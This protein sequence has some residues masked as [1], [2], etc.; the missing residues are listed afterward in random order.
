MEDESS[1]M[2][3]GSTQ[4]PTNTDP[5][6]QNYSKTG[7]AHLYRGKGQRDV[8]WRVPVAHMRRMDV[9]QFNGQTERDRALVKSGLEAR[10]CLLRCFRMISKVA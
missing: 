5:V 2:M 4:R 7:D 9:V 1:T 10:L 3:R 6:P 8:G